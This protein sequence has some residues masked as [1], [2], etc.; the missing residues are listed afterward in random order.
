MLLG[1]VT[2]DIVRVTEGLYAS[3]LGG[4]TERDYSPVIGRG[5]NIAVSAP[6][7]VEDG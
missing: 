5:P 1:N 2:G 4:S 3:A 6:D 7:T